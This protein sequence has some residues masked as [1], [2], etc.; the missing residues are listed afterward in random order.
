MGSYS[1]YAD[2]ESA[3][4]DWKPGEEN[5]ATAFLALTF[6]LIL[7]VNIGI[8]RVFKRK[9]GLYFWSLV[10]ATWGCAVDTIGILLKNF[11]PEWGTRIWPFWTVLILCG[12]S[13]FATAECVILYSRLHLVNQSPKVQRNVLIMI[14]IGSL[15][16]V[17]PNCVM[18]FP[19]Y[20][21]DPKVSSVWSPR[22][23]I[24]D[25]TSQLGFS[26]LEGIISGVY[27]WSLINILKLKS[28]VRQRRV[29]Y[30][31]LYVNVIVI[32]V[33]I[34]VTVLIFLN[35]VN[36]AYPIQV[37]SYALKFKLEFVVLN[38]LM[39]VAARGV[40]R[41]SF[42]ER[43]YHT[44]M[45]APSSGLGSGRVDE[46]PL[47]NIS[48]STQSSQ[49]EK[50]S[51]RPGGVPAP[52]P[53]LSKHRKTPR[54]AYERM[55]SGERVSSFR[56]I[57]YLM[58][59]LGTGVDS[60]SNTEQK[61]TNIWDPAGYEIRLKPGANQTSK[62]D[63][64]ATKRKAKHRSGWYDEDEDDEEEEEEEEIGLHMWENRG[65]LIMDVPWL[66]DRSGA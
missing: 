3:P 59:S 44:Q 40:R 13:S 62:I 49:S 4:P 39:A 50:K 36:L 10:V 5:A 11:K 42:A 38:Q 30:D 52:S 43:R 37:F 15:A 60:D 28:N 65:K 26:L 41:D 45:E 22:M 24:V 20:D 12:W 31:L 23:A 32:S 2:A 54:N 53:A 18:M 63:A 61:D 46:I 6:Y 21:V 27:I 8:H 33:D 55:E 64:T 58:V 35:Q 48:G 1:P 9:Q 66:R 47:G 56:E 17:I 25:R 16:L 57:S 34:V 51:S 29:M 7:D 19:A 14:I